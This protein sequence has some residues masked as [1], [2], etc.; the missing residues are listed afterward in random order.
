M[1]ILTINNIG[2]ANV[3]V[4]PN[5]PYAGNGLQLWKYPH[6]VTYVFE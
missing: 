6:V 5:I 2:I 3:E 4:P 1:I